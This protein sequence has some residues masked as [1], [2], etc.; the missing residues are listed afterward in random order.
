MTEGIKHGNMQMEAG[1]WIDDKLMR[2]KVVGQ[3]ERNGWMDEDGMKHGGEGRLAPVPPW[4]YPNLR[5]PAG[6]WLIFNPLHSL[7]TFYGM[8][9]R[10]G[11][12]TRE[13]G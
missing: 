3:Q 8:K 12:T 5:C 9:T 13:D 11:Q 2:M 4:P 7:L 1:E 6:I 10:E